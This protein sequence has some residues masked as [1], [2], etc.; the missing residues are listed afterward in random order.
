MSTTL[1]SFDEYQTSVVHFWY[2]NTHQQRMTVWRKD[3]FLL[4][5]SRCISHSVKFAVRLMWIPFISESMKI[6]STLTHG[7]R[8]ISTVVCSMYCYAAT[9]I[10]N[11]YIGHITCLWQYD[12]TQ[13]CNTLHHWLY[14][15]FYQEMLLFQLSSPAYGL[16]WSIHKSHTAY[17]IDCQHKNMTC[18][19]K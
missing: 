12:A 6:I 7:A 4:C 5:C 8:L 15:H 3:I 13:K 17:V 19:F 11:S 2:A 16:Q 10:A 9:A 18:C 14:L 1:T